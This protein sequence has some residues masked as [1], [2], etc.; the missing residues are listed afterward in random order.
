MCSYCG[1]RSIT[2]IG[3]FSAEHDDIVNAAGLLRRAAEAGDAAAGAAHAHALGHLLH[4]HTEAEEQGLF[5]ELRLDPD[6]TEHVDALCAE[7]QALDRH[8]DMI[9]GGD[10]SG[11]HAFVDLLRRHID[12]EENGLFPAAAVALDGP[13]WERVVATT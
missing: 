9:T 4:P 12:R 13:A 10:L 7:H 3:R 1:C 8:L 6:F 5:A 2:V 11:V